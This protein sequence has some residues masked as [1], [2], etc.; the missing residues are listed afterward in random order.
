MSRSYGART[1]YAEQGINATKRS[2]T[3]IEVK[4]YL[5][6]DAKEKLVKFNE[7]YPTEKL[8]IITDRGIADMEH[9]FILNPDIETYGT[10]LSEYLKVIDT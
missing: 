8:F 9:D 4:G 7:L 5:R 6:D 2:N 10:S 3:Y 1:V